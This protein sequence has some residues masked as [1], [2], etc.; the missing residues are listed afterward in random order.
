MLTRQHKGVSMVYYTVFLNNEI[1]ISS[2]R[3]DLIETIAPY[4]ILA[5]DV[6]LREIYISKE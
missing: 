2:L 6:T 4:K 1:F 5:I 3:A